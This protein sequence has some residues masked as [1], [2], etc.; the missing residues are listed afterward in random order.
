[1]RFVAEYYQRG[2]GPIGVKKRIAGVR[3]EAT[4]TDHAH[5]SGPV[6]SGALLTL[7]MAM[8]GRRQVLDD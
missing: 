4:D 1:V 3:P 8:A 2:G 7:V 6:A 5:G